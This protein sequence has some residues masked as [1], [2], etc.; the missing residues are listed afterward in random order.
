MTNR[1]RT[2]LAAALVLAAGSVVSAEVVGGMPEAAS[3][4]MRL[5]P[6]AAVHEE[7]GRVRILYGVPMTPGLDARSA[8]NSFIQMHG[9]AFGCGPLTVQEEWSADFLDGSKTVFCYQQYLNGLPVE[10]GCLKVLVQNGPVPRVAYAAGTLAPL[11]M[12]G[13]FPE[14][15]LD[16]DAAERLVRSAA[17][18]R[19]IP[20]WSAP[21]LVVYQGNGDW[22]APVIAWKFVGESP[23]PSDKLRKTFFV[24]ASSGRVLFVR[25]EIYFFTDV[26]GS[27]QGNGSPGTYPDASYN[28]PALLNMPLMRASITGGSSAYTDVNGLFTI[29]NSG[30]TPVA[31]TCGVNGAGAGNWVNVVPTA[32]TPITASLSNIT[33]P[34]PANLV[35]NQTPSEQLTAQVNAFIVPT[36]THNYFKSRAPSFTGIDLAIPANTGVSGTCNAFYSANTINFYNSG[37]GCVNT[38]YSSVISH[39]YGHFIVAHLG[40]SG[41]GLAQNAFGEGYGDTNAEMIWN[42][43]ICGRGFYGTQSSNVRDPITSNIQYPCS[44]EIHTCGMVLSG[45]WWG[46]R[47]NMGTLL[48]EPAGLEATRALEV[49]WSL[50]TTGGPDGSNAAGASTAI[51]VLTADDDDANLANG[52]PHYYQICPAFASHNIQCPVVQLLNFAY[53][54][55]RPTQITP[56]QP[57]QVAVNVVGNAG[58]PAP[59][60]GVVVYRI[61]NGTWSTAPMSQG[62]PN[63]YTATI[64]PVPCGQYVN[65]YFG[66]Q[67]TGSATV[68]YD[69]PNAP[70]S[71][72]TAQ[73]LSNISTTV[74]ANLNFQTDP[75]WTVTNDPSL[76]TGAW[77]R[78][79]PAPT[80]TAGPAADFDGSGMCWVTD[81]RVG[82]G[83]G[84]YDVDGGPTVLTTG[85][86]DLSGFAFAKVQF[87]RFMYCLG[88]TPDVLVFQAS[89]DNGATWTT[90][91]S[92]GNAAG[93]NQ[94]QFDVPFHT[95]Q[96][97]FRWS[98]AD[99]PSDSI[100]EAAIDAFRLTGYNCAAA[101]CYANCDQSTTPPILNVLDF[102]CF[103]NRF[104]AGDSYANCDGS[105]TPPVLNILDFTCFMS[106]FAAG[107]S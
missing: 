25:D 89:G 68:L 83:N 38:A 52:T 7:Q 94:V 103:L 81:N 24:D 70:S 58:T 1:S 50:I 65:Y 16:G 77:E 59:G 4:L 15:K 22:T 88:G 87:A 29:S 41:G 21:Q 30:A 8:A 9:E 98:V 97:Q 92:A 69:P 43:Y 49:K 12:D 62:A 18:Y 36:I 56:G 46:T 107:C 76:T 75:G 26:N 13:G 60:T 72:N 51:E 86:Y 85:T 99:N 102:T 48:G 90:L 101:A 55:G 82:V 93:W 44:Q 45:M 33:P 5:Y 11:P 2:R 34:G 66:A 6:G 3:Q 84:A 54:N 14:P 73:A 57:T 91:E 106:Q 96:V 31:L 53:P 35:L 28:P 42:D 17:A 95:A 23:D 37:G 64:P 78:A 104:A 74:V 67:A 10:Y 100:T 79:V 80:G 105:T 27:I 63:Q 47:T 39:E 61:N 40:P 20:S 19:K 71:Y 32:G